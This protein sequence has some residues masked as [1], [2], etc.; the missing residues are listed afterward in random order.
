MATKFQSNQLKLGRPQKELEN[1]QEALKAFLNFSVLSRNFHPLDTSQAALLKVALE[2]FLTGPPK[3]VHYELLFEK[4]IHALAGRA[5]MNNEPLSYK[6]ILDIWNTYIA[7]PA[8]NTISV[9]NMVEK[10]LREALSN[11]NKRKSGP[12]AIA[13][14]SPKKARTAFCPNWNENAVPPFCHNQQA[15]GGCLDAANTFFYHKCSVRV[16]KRCCGSSK[17]NKHTH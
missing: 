1:A 11:K 6:D 5:Q 17:H 7:P 13:S 12:S 3:V 15:N 2:K 16:G 9:E 8:M 10:K 4:F 14:N